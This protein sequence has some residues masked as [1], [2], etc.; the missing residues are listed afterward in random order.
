MYGGYWQGLFD[1]NILHF[2]MAGTA[3]IKQLMYDFNPTNSNYRNNTWS[4]G[5]QAANQSQRFHGPQY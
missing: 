1:N 4:F 3:N 2:D 5:S